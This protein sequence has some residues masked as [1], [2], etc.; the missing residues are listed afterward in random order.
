MRPQHHLFLAMATLISVITFGTEIHA[1]TL[2]APDRGP[3]ITAMAQAVGGPSPPLERVGVFNPAIGVNGDSPSHDPCLL[4]RT[5]RPVEP[6]ERIGTPIRAEGEGGPGMLIPRDGHAAF[7]ADRRYLDFS[8]VTDGVSRGL[9]I[10]LDRQ[11]HARLASTVHKSMGHGGAV[12]ERRAG[13]QNISSQLAFGG[14][15]SFA[16][17]KN[18]SPSNDGGN[19]AD[20]MLDKVTTSAKLPKN[21]DHPSP[22]SALIVLFGLIGVLLWG[23]R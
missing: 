22:V 17:L 7:V 9:P 14:E 2:G 19:R 8:L 20:M 11:D 12:K 5:Y 16:P 6:A 21:V 4:L 18:G 15:P 10:V 3:S 13:V 23:R 1:D